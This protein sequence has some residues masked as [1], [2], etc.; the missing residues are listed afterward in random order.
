VLRR[1]LALALIA[2]CGA[3]AHADPDRQ[4]LDSLR[5]EGNETFA[6]G[7]LEE[8]VA[9]VAT[10]PLPWA[11]PQYFERGTLAG[12]RRRLLRFYRSQ[13]F[14]Q[15]KVASRVSTEGR[16]A[17]VRFRITEGPPTRV[18]TLEIR[19][20]TALPPQERAELLDELPLAVGDRMTEPSY[21]A[22]RAELQRRLREIGYA[23][24]TAS[25]EVNVDVAARAADVA[26][27]VNPG[28]PLRFGRV[29]VV[30]AVDVPRSAILEQAAQE[31]MPATPSSR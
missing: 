9:L 22:T 17:S 13:G 7:E 23:D 10:A 31:R 18:R 3:C 27:T 6:D 4:V 28:P 20:T 12:D 5:F 24:A 25:G 29:G 15:A 21:D 14:Y 30:G 11:E 26:I 19:T 2:T 1:L 8:R 16:S